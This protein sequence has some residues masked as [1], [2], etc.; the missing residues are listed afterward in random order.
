MKVCAITGHRPSRFPFKDNEDDA[1]CKKLKKNIK[2]ELKYLYKKGVHT[3]WI[4]GAEG[5]DMW[6]AELLIQLKSYEAYK[7]IKIMV[8]IPFEGHDKNWT[9]KNIKRLKNIIKYSEEVVVVNK[10]EG[11]KQQLY[12]KRNQ[13]IV[14]KADCL[15][16]VY[17]KKNITARS[18]TNMTLQ[19][20]LKKG[21]PITVVDC[22]FCDEWND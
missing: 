21:I 12:R 3:F 11:T 2:K 7:D 1:M 13:Y 19:I 5:V 22:S 15:L 6:S 18:G 20:A 17:H 9:E 10:N 14:D 4:G 16:A 8:A